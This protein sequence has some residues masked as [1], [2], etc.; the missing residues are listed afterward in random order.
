MGGWL[1]P[2][3]SPPSSDELDSIIKNKP[4][5]RAPGPDGF[6]GLFLKTCWDI[7]KKDFYELAPNF[8]TTEFLWNV[9][10]GKIPFPER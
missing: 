10:R 4:V 5:D 9:A 8:S 2:A 3:K 6:N 7:I 1:K